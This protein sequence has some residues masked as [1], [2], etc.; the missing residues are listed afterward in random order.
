M[1]WRSA[2]A[3]RNGRKIIDLALEVMYKLLY[4]PHIFY[5]FTGA[6]LVEEFKRPGFPLLK[7]FYPGGIMV[8]AENRRVFED[9]FLPQPATGDLGREDSGDGFC[10]KLHQ[11]PGLV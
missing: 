8:A 9:R 7:G 4:F 5:V 6:G 11:D 10:Q 2:N 3:W 1:K